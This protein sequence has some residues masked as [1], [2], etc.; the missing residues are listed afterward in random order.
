MHQSSLEMSVR[1]RQRTARAARF[2]ARDTVL[3]PIPGRARLAHRVQRHELPYCVQLDEHRLFIP[4]RPCRFI[5]HSCAPTA[6]WGS[7]ASGRLQLEILKPLRRGDPITVDYGF[8]ARDAF[9]CF[10][11]HRRC[12]GWSSGPSVD[13]KEIPR[14]LSTARRSTRPEDPFCLL[15]TAFVRNPAAFFKRNLQH[16]TPRVAVLRGAIDPASARRFAHFLDARVKPLLRPERS[17][18]DESILRRLKT[19]YGERPNKCL[20][21][22]TLFLQ[23][24]RGTRYAK[25]AAMGLVDL[26]E[27]DLFRI[28][29]EQAF[30][31]SLAADPGVQIQRYSEGDYVGLH[32]DH[33][34]ESPQ[35]RG[36][37]VD[38]HVSIPVRATQQT[39]VCEDHG[40]PC[41]PLD[42]SQEPMVMFHHLPHWHHLTPLVGDHR[43]LVAI[44]YEFSEP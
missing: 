4:D 39:L 30:G 40:H 29:G 16:L 33:L 2:L 41:V 10:C 18:I 8:G 21:M 44:S 12:S 23:Y 1:D 19:N 26:F 17:G 25:A 31:R 3:E 7:T 37:Y 38:V 27:D 35:H 20:R 14:R 36:G 22:D 24:R 9:P 32:A 43:W 13:G 28:L 42:V 11:G 15:S 34:P 5:E 6:Q